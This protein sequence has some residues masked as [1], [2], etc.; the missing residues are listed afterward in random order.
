MARQASE[1][2]SFKSAAQLKGSSHLAPFSPRCSQ[3]GSF[4]LAPFL[5]KIKDILFP[6]LA[7]HSSA[8]ALTGLL[9][10]FAKHWEPGSVIVKAGVLWLAVISLFCTYDGEDAGLTNQQP[11]IV[12]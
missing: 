10:F 9:A 1:V 11:S 12:Y 2:S 8:Q 6:N 7:D 5:S 4:N 3:K